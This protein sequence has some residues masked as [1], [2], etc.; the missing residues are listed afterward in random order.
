MRLKGVRR[1]CMIAPLAWLPVTT[2]LLLCPLL[3]LAVAIGANTRAA[4]APW[5]WRQLLLLH[6]RCWL[7]YLLPRNFP[8][9]L[10][11]MPQSLQLQRA[12]SVN[13][14]SSRW[15]CPNHPPLIPSWR[16]RAGPALTIVTAANS[17]YFSCLGNMVS[18]AA[19]AAA[20]IL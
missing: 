7:R 9:R 19:A 17:L 11:F 6:A 14:N 18:T 1:T 3:L 12:L 13:G 10:S 15:R 20:T 2:Y 8:L 16:C 4:R 5:P